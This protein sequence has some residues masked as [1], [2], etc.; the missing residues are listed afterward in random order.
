[1]MLTFA[2]QTTDDSF[3]ETTHKQCQPCFVGHS[4]IFSLEIGVDLRQFLI[5]SMSASGFELED[6]SWH[7]A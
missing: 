1:V 6:N 7:T 5:L 4:A 2:H 3:Y